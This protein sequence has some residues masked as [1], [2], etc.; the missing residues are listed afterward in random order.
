M[1]KP[2]VEF[3][4]SRCFRGAK[5]LGFYNVGAAAV[6]GLARSVHAEVRE[7]WTIDEVMSFA[8]VCMASRFLEAK[9]VGI[10][11]VARY[12]RSFT[13]SLLGR[14]KG[15][16]ADGH[17]SNWATTDAICGL[18]IGPLVVAHPTL[19]PTVASWAGARSL[20]VRRAGVVGLIPSVR[21]GHALDLAYGVAT[22]LQGD[23]EDLIQKAV[24][25]MLR[26]A[27]KADEK[28][29]ERYLRKNGPRIPRTTLRYAIERFPPARRRE[30][31]ASTRSTARA[32]QAI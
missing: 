32:G 27:G 6:R 9:G 13:P 29:L 21:K 1:S 16:L 26:E 23:K 10:E 8:D 2:S 19:A 15:W 31:L 7:S 28:R 4:A 25:W 3:D 18:L 20:W 14:W 22:R 11:L 30:L 24:G 12:R 5:G 17:A